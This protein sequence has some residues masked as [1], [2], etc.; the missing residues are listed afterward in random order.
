MDGGVAKELSI[1]NTN[2]YPDFIKSSPI[3]TEVYLSPHENN[4]EYL[5]KNWKD[6]GN[7]LGKIHKNPEILIKMPP[8]PMP[9]DSSKILK[10]EFEQRTKAE[11]LGISFHT[12]NEIVA[13]WMKVNGVSQELLDFKFD[14]SNRRYSKINKD[15]LGAPFGSPINTPNPI[16]DAVM[17]YHYSTG[18]T[19]MS[20]R[21][22]LETMRP[23]ALGQ[24]YVNKHSQAAIEEIKKI[25]PNFLPKNPIEFIYMPD[26]GGKGMY[27]GEVGNK[28]YIACNP[29]FDLN[30][31]L[32]SD[33]DFSQYPSQ[34]DISS[35][36]HEILHALTAEK[37][38]IV[39]FFALKNNFD[40]ID[41]PIISNNPYETAKNLIKAIGDKNNNLAEDPTMAIN[42]LEG[43][44]YGGQIS[45][46]NSQI[47]SCDDLAQKAVLK[48]VKNVLWE[49]LRY[50]DENGHPF[51]T[52]ETNLFKR[53]RDGVEYINK[54]K[55]IYGKEK[56]MDVIL[57]IDYIA[58]SSYKA[59]S[60]EITEIKKDP[61][62]LPMRNTT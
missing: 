51:N 20:F 2:K 10:E 5:S 3:K 59:D 4:D 48:K 17:E 24:E 52:E 7:L 47:N 49:E 53:Y 14:I 9:D 42:I 35:E 40:N 57:N 45:I 12:N 16:V 30:P 39:N 15:V 13:D 11:S 37:I 36:I 54:I 55:N 22:L 34:H 50:Y 62:K 6:L 31:Y 46:L 23:L 43:L 25:S 8:L 56:F 58:L 18:S 61:T 33:V 32:S 19:E 21:K 60:S 1:T 38:G 44:A 29:R 28:H 27:L 41:P 26:L